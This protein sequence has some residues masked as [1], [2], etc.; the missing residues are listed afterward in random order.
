MFAFL[1]NSNEIKE[2]YK[3]YQ[4]S[5]SEQLCL[6]NIEDLKIEKVEVGVTTELVHNLILLNTKQNWG[7]QF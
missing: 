6:R 2:W 7:M 4:R 5:Q 3:N 1:Y